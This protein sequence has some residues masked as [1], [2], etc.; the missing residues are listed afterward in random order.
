MFSTHRTEVIEGD[1]H[2]Y[3]NRQAA[4]GARKLAIAAGVC[5]LITHVTSVGALI[6][7]TPI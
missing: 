4:I 6:L 3:A 1:K 7:Y 2:I 5:Y